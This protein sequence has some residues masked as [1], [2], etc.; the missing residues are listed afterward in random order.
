MKKFKETYNSFFKWSGLTESE[1]IEGKSPKNQKISPQTEWTSHFPL[2]NLLFSEVK[3]E[4][5]TANGKHEK[6]FLEKLLLCI[7]IDEEGESIADLLFEYLNKSDILFL[8]NLSLEKKLFDAQ[9]QLIVRIYENNLDES[10]IGL[11][12]KETT[13]KYIK[14]YI[15][16]YVRKKE[17]L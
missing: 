7:L 10:F 6:P 8:S 4:L 2:M 9:R 12:E 14:D 1:F 15:S 3:G 11:F 17:E 13:F 5:I 16:D